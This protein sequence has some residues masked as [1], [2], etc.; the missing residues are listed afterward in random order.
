MFVSVYAVASIAGRAAGDPPGA[1]SVCPKCVT[2]SDEVHRNRLSCVCTALK[3][4]DL[5]S[6]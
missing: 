4:K 1:L 6:C 5:R 3:S 2:T